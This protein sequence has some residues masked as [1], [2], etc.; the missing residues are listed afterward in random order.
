MEHQHPTTSATIEE[1]AAALSDPAQVLAH[2]G[3]A[4]EDQRAILASWASDARAIP[5]APALRR[6]ESGAVVR[7][8]DI[9]LALR[10]IDQRA[11]NGGDDDP[12]PVPAA[13]AVPPRIIRTVAVA[14]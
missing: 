3:L 6:L 8:A 10:D 12:P 2:A 4:P 14:A 11:G 5:G 1:F 9:L 13:A 7:L